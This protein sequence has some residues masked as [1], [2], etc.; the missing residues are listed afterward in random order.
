M[1][2]GWIS[3]PA[4]TAATVAIVALLAAS[5]SSP[6]PSPSPSPTSPTPSVS[7][8]EPAPT[9]STPT[10]EPSLSGAATTPVVRPP[11]DGGFGL[12]VGV[13]LAS[14]P[15]YDR[16]VLEFD[17][18]VPGYRVEYT[19]GPVIED[20]SGDTMTVAGD[21][22]LTIRVEPSSRFD[23]IGRPD[24]QLYDGPTRIASGGGAVREAVL[25]GDF[26]GVLRWVLGV[27]GE[28]PF[29]VTELSSPP[30]LVVDVASG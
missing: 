14:H 4:A 23:L 9:S 19:D 6:V 5:C 8:S 30:R 17:A 28:Q 29:V 1:R 20:P 26:E 21:H 3:R 18:V 11:G 27:D 24:T 7:S 25:V 22:V 12:L 15:G 10:P 2:T 13:R 16:F